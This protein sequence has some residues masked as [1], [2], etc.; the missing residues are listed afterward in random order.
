M[1]N[2]HMPFPII[3]PR[4]ST[5]I[6]YPPILASNDRTEIF[7]GGLMHIIVVPFDVFRCL[8]SSSTDFA[9][10]RVCMGSLMATEVISQ[11]SVVRIYA[12]NYTYL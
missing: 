10:R 7:L 5:A 3:L 6:F 8:E 2:P 11:Q 4:K 9:L 1:L 12:Q